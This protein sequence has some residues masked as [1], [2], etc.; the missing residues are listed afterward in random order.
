MGETDRVS[1]FIALFQEM[2]EDDNI[3]NATRLLLLPCVQRQRPLLPF[4]GDDSPHQM[5]RDGELTRAARDHH[6]S[7]CSLLFLTDVLVGCYS[8][9]SGGA[10]TS[11]QW[12]QK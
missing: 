10:T 6:Q 11:A 3:V 4:S 12:N 7:Q 9:S 8:S 1:V 5:G 2:G